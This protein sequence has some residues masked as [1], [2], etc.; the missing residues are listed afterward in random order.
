MVVKLVLRLEKELTQIQNS[1]TV[2]G[3]FQ[4]SLIQPAWLDL[5]CLDEGLL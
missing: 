3:N 1:A 5:A 4:R 2:A